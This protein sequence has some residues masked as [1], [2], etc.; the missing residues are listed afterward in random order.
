MKQRGIHYQ[1][2]EKV[3]CVKWKVNNGIVLLGANIDGS[4]FFSSAQGR[5]K[6]MSRK[7]S[8]PCPHLIFLN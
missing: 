3:I 6:G 2:F 4:I 7:T 1:Y 5:K 8:F